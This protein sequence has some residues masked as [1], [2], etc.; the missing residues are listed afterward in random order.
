VNHSAYFNRMCTELVNTPNSALTSKK[1][2]CY[3]IK[4][5]PY[6]NVDTHPLCSFFRSSFSFLLENVHTCTH[7]CVTHEQVLLAINRKH[8]QK[9]MQACLPSKDKQ[10]LKR[11]SIYG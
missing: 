4:F 3:G 7:N 6:C 5:S 10:C 1:F 2:S 11:S 8:M 9:H